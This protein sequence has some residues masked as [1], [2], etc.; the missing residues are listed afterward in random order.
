MY[1]LRKEFNLCCSHLLNNDNLNKQDNIRLFGKCNQNHGHN[2]K[3]VLCFKTKNL[4]KQTGMILNFDEIKNTF[5]KF[6]D[7]PF[8]HKNLNTLYQFKGK[9]PTAENMSKIFYDILKEKFG[10]IYAVEIHETDGAIAIYE[11]EDEN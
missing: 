9:I 4:D 6:I 3:V 7:I 5:N 1:K 2:Y 8:D 11:E 10:D